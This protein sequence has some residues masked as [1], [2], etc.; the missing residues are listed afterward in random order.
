MST[1]AK[2]L[3]GSRIALTTTPGMTALGTLAN[4]SSEDTDSAIDPTSA[5]YTDGYL[6]FDLMLDVGW[7]SAP[8][9]ENTI[10]VY[11]AHSDGTLFQEYTVGASPVNP[12]NGF[13]GSFVVT[14]TGTDQNLV[15]PNILTP[16]KDFY[17][18]VENNSGVAFTS[19]V[20]YMIPHTEQGV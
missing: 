6:Y 2:I 13:V 16:A 19:A 3:G 1:T 10:D 20:L 14:G 4:G 12:P 8:T 7:G 18:I 15:L 9:D 5:S 17:I 11:I